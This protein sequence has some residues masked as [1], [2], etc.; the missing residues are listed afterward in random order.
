[1]LIKGIDDY[2][3]QYEAS[4]KEVKAYSYGGTAVAVSNATQMKQD[5][6]LTLSITLVALLLFLWFF[7][8]RKRIPFIMLLPVAFGALFAVVGIYL[9]KG[10]ISNIGCWFYRVGYCY[11]LFAALLRAL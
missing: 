5:T 11:Q 3:K 7:F 2:I 9:I 10:S 6:I 4:H 8:R 1:V